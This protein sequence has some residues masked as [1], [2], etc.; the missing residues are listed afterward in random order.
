MAKETRAAPAA[1]PRTKQLHDLDVDA[2]LADSVQIYPEAIQEEYV[3]LPS[4]LAYWGQRYT[5]ALRAFLTAK[6]NLDRTEARLKIACRAELEA[7]NS[8]VTESM[9][10]AA[11]DQH[12]EMEAARLGHIATEV[13]KVRLGGVLDA[14]RAKKDMLVSLGAHVRSE[15]EHDPLLRDQSRGRAALAGG[16]T[17][18]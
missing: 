8:K 17:G 18:G 7:K 14:I 10:S 5:D 6:V 11:V 13:E 16:G 1:P 15:M 4:D 2:Y 3:R 9:V 12:P